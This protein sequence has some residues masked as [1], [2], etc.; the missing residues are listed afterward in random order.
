MT[1]SEASSAIVACKGLQTAVFEA[2]SNE[3]VSSGT[4][5]K[6]TNH[7]FDLILLIYDKDKWREALLVHWRVERLVTAK[8]GGKKAIHATCKADIT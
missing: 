7:N 2:I 8:D 6:Y 3:V 5:E 4:Q 1:L